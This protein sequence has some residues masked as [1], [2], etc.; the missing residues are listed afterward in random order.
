MC[1]VSKLELNQKNSKL[2]IFSTDVSFN[3]SLSDS[4]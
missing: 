1:Y 2:T 3:D 4:M